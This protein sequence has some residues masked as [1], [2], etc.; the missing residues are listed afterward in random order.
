M[1]I[2]HLSDEEL[3]K[4]GS[5]FYCVYFAVQLCNLMKL[6]LLVEKTFHL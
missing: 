5:S 4:T 6:Y 1:Y 3:T 2:N